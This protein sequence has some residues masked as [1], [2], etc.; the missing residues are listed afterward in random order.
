VRGSLFSLASTLDRGDRPARHPGRALASCLCG[1]AS[2][3]SY[4]SWSATAAAGQRQPW[5]RCPPSR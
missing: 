3:S 2:A 5:P 1:R 4:R